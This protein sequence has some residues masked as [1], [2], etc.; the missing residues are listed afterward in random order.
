MMK[1]PGRSVLKTNPKVRPLSFGTYGPF[2][3]LCAYPVMVVLLNVVLSGLI[4][5]IGDRGAVGL[6]VVMDKPVL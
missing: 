2:D 6:G 4:V 3:M 1:Y 5:V